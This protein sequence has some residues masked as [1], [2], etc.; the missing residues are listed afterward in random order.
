[1]KVNLDILNDLS[2]CV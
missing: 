1:M 2:V